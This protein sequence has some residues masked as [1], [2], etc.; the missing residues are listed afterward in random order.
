MKL[1]IRPLSTNDIP[2]FPLLFQQQGWDKPKSQFQ[3]Y[4][5]EQQSGLRQ[6]FVAEAEGEPAGYVTL[7]PEDAHGPFAHRGIPTISDFNVLE[8]FQRQGIGARLMDAAEEAARQTSPCV[9]L[10]VGLHKG[11]GPAQRMYIKRGYIPDGSGVW[12][13]DQPLAPYAP[14]R[15]DDDLVLYLIRYF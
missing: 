7:L 9:C 1:C 11:Y 8:R 12:Y 13:Q 10:G 14:C 15:N 3:R 4:Y 5:E 6:V 2:R